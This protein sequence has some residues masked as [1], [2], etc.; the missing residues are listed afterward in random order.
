MFLFLFCFYYSWVFYCL[1]DNDF[2]WCS[3]L[4]FVLVLMGNVYCYFEWND[5]YSWYRVFAVWK[6]MFLGIDSGCYCDGYGC[7]VLVF[8]LLG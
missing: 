2:V 6:L 3:W 1:V 7:Y 5:W 8:G 4:V